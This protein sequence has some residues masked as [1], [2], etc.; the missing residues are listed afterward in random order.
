MA[1]FSPTDTVFAGFRFVRER[2]ATILVWAGYYLVATAVASVAMIGIGGDSLTSLGIAARGASPDPQQVMKLADEV[3][4]ATAFGA[5]LM[6]VFGAVLSTAILRVRTTPG[7]HP[8]GGLRLG[9]GELRLLGAK[10]LVFAAAV[11]ALVPAA[12]V[13]TLLQL[14]GLPIPVGVAAGL[15]LLVAPL[16]IR[17]SLAGVVSQTEGQL[18]PLRSLRL[19]GPLF[20]RLLGAYMLLAAIMLVILVLV[21]IIFTALIG[22][23]TLGGGG[24]MDQVAL[25]A[26]Q[27]RFE[28]LNPLVAGLYIL[29]NLA[30]VWV[31]VVFQAVFL[32]VAVDAYQAALQEQG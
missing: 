3:L 19:T 28:G 2:P 24:N 7:P 11:L 17:M 1:K 6:I 5:L 31:L 10:G 32:S 23:A 14:G 25:A 22:A 29:S 26:M 16:M 15:L 8:W 18:N 9:G 12:F 13:A 30:Q 21:A 27:G 20:W 4:P